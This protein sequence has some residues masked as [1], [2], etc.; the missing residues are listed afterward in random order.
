M[1]PAHHIHWPPLGVALLLAVLTLWLNQLGGK[2]PAIDDTAGFT[3]DPDYYVAGFDA[4]AFDPEGR[5]RHRLKAAHLIHYMDD[6][7]T[8]LDEPVFSEIRTD[9]KLEVRSRR[10]LLSA[11]N[12][13]VHF[14]DQVRVRQTPASGGAP[15]TMDTEYLHVTPD[16]RTMRTDRHVVL[17]QGASIITA[18]SLF[19]DGNNNLLSL[20]GGVRGSYENSR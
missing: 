6:D 13:H 19:A 15:V 2:L 10:A 9:G 3:H 5:P 4:L 11:D 17:R 16:A 1:S 12:L 18:N 8:V 14:L 20:G 7:T